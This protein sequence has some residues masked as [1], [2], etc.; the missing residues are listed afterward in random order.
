MGFRFS[1]LAAIA[2]LTMAGGIGI[3]AAPTASAQVVEV[4]PPAPTPSQKAPAVEKVANVATSRRHLSDAMKGRHIPVAH[5]NRASGE[6]AHR[7]WRKR[8][9]AGRG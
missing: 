7:N 5:K 8:R 9:S 1:N 4:V 6:R 2:A 3:A